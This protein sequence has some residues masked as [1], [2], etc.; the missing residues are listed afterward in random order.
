LSD[1]SILP[2]SK[3]EKKMAQT[4]MKCT[5]SL[6]IDSRRNIISPDK[7]KRKEGVKFLKQ[8]IEVASYLGSDV[9]GGPFYGAWGEFTGHMRTKDEWNYCKEHLSEVAEFAKEKGVVLAV[10]PL[11]RYETYFLNTAQDARK[12]VEEINHP[13]LKILLDTYHM[14]IEEECFYDSIKEAGRYLFHLH[15]CENNRGIPGAG[16]VNWKEVFEAI[17]EIGYV[18]WGVIES[19][20]PGASEE[21]ASRVRLWRKVAPSADVLA[22]KGLEFF[23]RCNKAG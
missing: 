16:H 8:R 2:I 11:N 12:L 6:A 21:I 22:R 17:K 20:V 15:L 19:F 23:N 5:F 3:I 18:R 13:N 7:G 1:L 10:E 14:N 4:D 9:I